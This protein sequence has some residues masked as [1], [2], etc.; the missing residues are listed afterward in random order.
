MYVVFFKVISDLKYSSI[1]PQPLSSP[2]TRGNLRV[3]VVVLK[4]CWH[5]V[6]RLMVKGSW[7]LSCY[8]IPWNHNSRFTCMLLHSRFPVFVDIYVIAG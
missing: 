3:V 1:Y 6:A 8:H 2:S 7:C 5:M 4:Y